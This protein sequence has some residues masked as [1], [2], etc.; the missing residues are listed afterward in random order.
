MQL[1]KIQIV[2]PKI[3]ELVMQALI[4][5]I[6]SGQIRVGEDLPS[7]RDLAER[8]GIGRG[9]LREC[10]AILEFL[11]AI[12]ANGNRKRVARDADFI[13]QAITFVRVSNQLDAGEDFNE[14][15][16]VNEVAI[17]GLAC[18][19]ATEKDLEAIGTAMK[20]LEEDP[21]DYMADVE[22]HA[23][24]AAASHNM[25]LAATMYDRGRAYSLFYAAGLHSEVSGLSPG[26]LRGGK[27]TG[28]GARQEG[29]EPP[30]GHRYR[31][32]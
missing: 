9:S 1:E 8:L 21:D 20:R 30:F 14:F 6:E 15:R 16:R 18:Q 5:A 23:A 29:N 26:D 3:P 28:R 12:E 27:R 22:F 10:L 19:R 32:C 7:E 11:G 2:S 17:A 13:R 31:I 24:L 25:M 4:N